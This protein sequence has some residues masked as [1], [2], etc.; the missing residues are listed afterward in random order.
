MS[1]GFYSIIEY[2]AQ[3]AGMLIAAPFLLHR[4]GIST[5]GLWMLIMAVVSGSGLVGVGVG[6]AALK[7]IA[8]H[9][10]AN[11][12]EAGMQ[13]LTLSLAINVL[14]GSLLAV[15]VWSLAPYAVSQ[16]FKIQLPMQTMATIA[17]RIGALILV[18]RCLES[19]CTGGLRAYERYKVSALISSS[20]RLTTIVAACAVVYWKHGVVAILL[21]TLA[22]S[23]GG[24]TAQLIALRRSLG[25]LL[26]VS[27]FNRRTFGRICRFG[28]FSWLQAVA[29]AVFTQADRILLGVLLG[30]TAV[31][32]YSI[33]IQIS[34]PIHGLIAAG[35]H[36]LFPHISARLSVV[37]GAQIDSIASSAMKLNLLATLVLCL[38]LVLFSRFVLRIWLGPAFARQTST[39]LSVIAL[40]FGFLALNVTGHYILLASGQVR[41]VSLLNLAGAA[42]ALFMMAVLAPRF[43]LIGAAVARLSYGPI[44]WIMY[45]RLRSV[46][47]RPWEEPR[48]A[49]S[50]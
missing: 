9:R 40:S 22:V 1:N 10:G 27:A 31:G 48:A 35:L 6:D 18:A 47:A 39:L 36:F 49:L 25:P 34:Q 45:Y 2:V 14:L 12:R 28:C 24:V 26:S 19:I 5:Y 33:C 13:V 38:P 15:L 7:Y 20:A 42:T 11:D 8:E 50:A 44:T 46:L 3:P 4:L 23:A 16:V 32:Y 43:G 41:L 37:P 30:T 21:C 29:S 17:L